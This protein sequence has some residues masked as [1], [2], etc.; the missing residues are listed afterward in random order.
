MNNYLGKK[1]R[2]DKKQKNCTSNLHDED[3]DIEDNTPGGDTNIFK[4][5]VFEP[6]FDPQDT[7]GEGGSMGIFEF[8]P[9]TGGRQEVVGDELE[10][11]GL[12]CCVGEELGDIVGTELGLLW[13][14]EG[15]GELGPEC[16][17][18]EEHSG[19]GANARLASEGAD[20]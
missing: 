10:M 6:S 1:P 13:F 9:L 3:A 19:L 12:V 16:Q 5:T 17:W 4:F 20:L 2:N 15:A 14:T 11:A 7:A 8:G 18:V